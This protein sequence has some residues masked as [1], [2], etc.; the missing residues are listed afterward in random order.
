ML[1]FLFRQGVP[2][3]VS[4]IQNISCFPF[5][6]CLFWDMESYSSQ[7]EKNIVALV[8]SGSRKED[9]EIHAH[10]DTIKEWIE[11]VDDYSNNVKTFESFLDIPIYSTPSVKIG[12]IVVVDTR[13]FSNV[14]QTLSLFSCDR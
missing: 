2:T 7:L 4:D 9:L 5:P 13:I 8:M 12:R 10:K 1:F 14:L 6:H 3:T 11:E